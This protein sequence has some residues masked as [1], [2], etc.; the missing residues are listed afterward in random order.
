MFI[1]L[2]AYTCYSLYFLFE[3]PLLFY[4]L[5]ELTPEVLIADTLNLSS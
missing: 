4:I 5:E 3:L 1:K 2:L